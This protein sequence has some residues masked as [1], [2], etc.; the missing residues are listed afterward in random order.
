MSSDNVPFFDT[1]ESIYDAKVLNEQ[2]KRYQ[3]LYDKFV[4]LYNTPPS[5]I[6]RAPG[7]VNLIVLSNNQKKHSAKMKIIVLVIGRTHRL[8]Q[9]CRPS[10]GNHARHSPRNAYPQRQHFLS[11][12][13]SRKHKPPIPSTR[14]Q[15]RH[16]QPISPRNNR[17]KNTRYPSPHPS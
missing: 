9:L 1:L 12:N 15:N 11:Y 13:H 4:D 2:R 7:R 5:H 14:N 3:N 17:P 16:I 8:L 10:H 6:V